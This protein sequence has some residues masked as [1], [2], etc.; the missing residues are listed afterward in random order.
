MSLGQFRTVLGGDV[1]SKALTAL[2][3]LGLVRYLPPADLAKWVHLSSVVILSTLLLGGFFNR[4]YILQ[5]SRQLSARGFRRLQVGSASLAY[6]VA[7][8]VLRPDYSPVE[9]GAG[10]ACTVAAAAFD[11]SRTYAQSK[12]RF[13]RYVS[14]DILRSACLLLIVLPAVFYLDSHR[15]GAVLMAQAFAFAL[16]AIVLPALPAE[17]DRAD[18]PMWAAARRLLG[19]RGALAL[20][21]YFALLALFG[22][23]PILLLERLADEQALAAFGS[24][25]RYYGLL[26]SIVIAANVVLLPKIVA[27]RE[28]D[29]ASSMRTAAQIVAVSLALL[30]GA[31]LAGFLLIPLVDG[32]KYPDAPKLFVMVSIGLVPGILSAP[33]VAFWLRAEGFIQLF[34]S[35]L[36]AVVAAAAVHWISPVD[37]ATAAAVSVP[38]GVLAQLAWLTLAWRV[39]KVSSPA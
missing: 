23:L 32:G 35:Q 8:A 6:C 21:G 36:L 12:A 37:A 9:L 31:C 11:F 10:L 26:L 27:A 20:V 38:A 1:A 7:M 19:S 22:Q 13:N 39:R 24:A 29:L 18:P 2:F 5:G 16:G 15:A 28:A 34:V 30:I 33:L 14:S 3:V 4:I 25:F 17:L